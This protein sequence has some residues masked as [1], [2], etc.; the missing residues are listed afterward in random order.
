VNPVAA[1]P[2]S[3]LPTTWRLWA[4]AA[5][6]LVPLGLRWRETSGM[7]S[8]PYIYY[9]DCAYSDNYYCTPDQFVPG[10]YSPGF[11]LH[12]FSSPARVFLVFA[13]IVLAL[14]AARTRTDA[15]RRLARAA[16]VA[17]GIAVVLALA[18]RSVPMLICTVLAL[19][20]TVP[21]VWVRPGARILA[22]GPAPR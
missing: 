22:P 20:L 3:R 8:S 15:T 2:L 6:C 16:T 11:A 1:D 5:L 18:G 10:T 7:L 4:A 9:G 13:L 14:V 19:V 21:V 12:G 17:I